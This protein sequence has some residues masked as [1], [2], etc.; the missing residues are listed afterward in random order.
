MP[1]YKIVK[2]LFC[3]IFLVFIINIEGCD[4]KVREK[5]EEVENYYK[6]YYVNNLEDKLVSEDYFAKEDDKNKLVKELIG[7]LTNIPD[8]ITLKK[9]IPDDVK[10]KDIRIKDD[11]VTINFSETYKQL[12]GISEIL[13]RACV[14]KTIC[15]IDGINKVEY[16]IEDQPLMYSETNPVG[17]MSGDDFIDNTGGETTYYQNVQISLYYTDAAGKKLYQTRHNVEFDGTISLEELVIRQLLAGPLENDK[18]APVLPAGT[19]INKVSF[20]DGICYV[21]FSKEFLEGRDGV[22]DDVIIYS[23]VNSLSDIGSVSKVQFWIDGKPVSSY[24]ETVPI[25]LPIERKLDIIAED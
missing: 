23:V 19:K 14:V 16:T 4:S 8:G 5:I 9:P 10:I 15:Q 24:R 6:I 18:L 22:S 3:L 11:C 20:K 1:N 17:A 12:I 25:D 21:D 13:R 2:Y 7:R